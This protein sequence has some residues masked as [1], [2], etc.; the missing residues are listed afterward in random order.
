MAVL[1][2]PVVLLMS[3]SKP[4]AVL[5]AGGVAEERMIT[6]AVLP[7]PVVLLKSAENRWPCCRCRL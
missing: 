6:V 3:A 7:L 5:G 4:V 2:M 1:L